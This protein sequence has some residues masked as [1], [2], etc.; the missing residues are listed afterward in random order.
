MLRVIRP[1][2]P[3]DCVQEPLHAMISRKNR[4][5]FAVLLPWR[6]QIYVSRSLKTLAANGNPPKNLLFAEQADEH[7][8]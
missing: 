8:V 7:C 1:G 3:A 5:L 4:F 2:E 6:N